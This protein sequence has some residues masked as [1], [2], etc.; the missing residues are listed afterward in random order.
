[1]ILVEGNGGSLKGVDQV[2]VSDSRLCLERVYGQRITH[3]LLDETDVDDMGS[4]L[5][6]VR[7]VKVGDRFFRDE[8]TLRW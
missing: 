4:P 5:L 3:K 7:L 2:L 1:M 6:F 8:G